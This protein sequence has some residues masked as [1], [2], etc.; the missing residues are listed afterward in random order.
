MR[1]E[2]YLWQTEVEA[3]AR[4]RRFDVVAEEALAVP[5][6]WLATLAVYR[7]A[8]YRVERRRD[9]VF[10][11]QLADADRRAHDPRLPED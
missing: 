4:S 6:G 1:P 11:R 7:A 5:A 2:T 3:H 8:G 9:G 10:R